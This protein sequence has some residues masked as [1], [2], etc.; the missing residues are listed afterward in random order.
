LNEE[1]VLVFFAIFR[2]YARTMSLNV[3]FCTFPDKDVAQ[4]IARGLVEAQLVACVNLV[5][6]V[7]SIYRWEGKVESAEEVLGVMKTTTEAYAALEARI[8]ELH[9]YE[10]PEIVAVPVELVEAKYAKWV[11]E[12]TRNP[13]DE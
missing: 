3:V 12:M 6:G 5:P 1:F 9:P 10:V 13:N 2:G 11:G 7:Q 8:R 4:R